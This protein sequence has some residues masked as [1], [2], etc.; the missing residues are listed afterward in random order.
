MAIS[1]H[2]VVK[3]EIRLGGMTLMIISTWGKC[4]WESTVLHLSQPVNN[5]SEASDSAIACWSVKVGTQV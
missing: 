4:L 1:V 5:M 3:K 2:V